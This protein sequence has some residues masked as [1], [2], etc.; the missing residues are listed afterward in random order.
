MAKYELP[1]LRPELVVC[2]A[3]GEGT[4]GR[5]GVHSQRERR[6]KCHRCHKTFSDT[7]GTPLYGLKHPTWLVVVVLTLLAF[8]C[9]LQAIV[10]AFGLDERTVSDW[11]QKAGR[12]AQRVQAE[13]VCNGQV[14]VGQVQG[15][16]FYVKT[17][18]G[19]VWIATG[20]SVF[21]RLFLWGALSIERN[22]ALVTQVVE[23]VKAAAQPQQPILWAVDGFT[24]WVSAILTLFRTSQHSGQRGR[25][26]LLVWPD[27]HIVQVVKRYAARRLV[28]VERRVV[29]G[30]PQAA[31]MLVCTTQVELG[32]FNT[33]YIERLNATFRTWLPQATRRS[34]TPAARR[35]QLE[36]A[37][38]WMAAVY[39]FCHLHASLQATPAM[40]AGLTDSL[41]SIDQ[42][43]RYRFRRE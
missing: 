14:D 25:P 13:V 33:A 21:S 19:A 24:A 35:S 8:G 17:Q 26:R 5:I 27:L 29:Y 10:A 4:N 43:L 38:F 1:P 2:P 11:Q 28:A 9:P 12:H 31:E 7:H 40:A 23:Q 32:C 41:W 39:N 18:C 30:A 34:R 42:L 15:D 3:C 20:M 6:Y 16:E 37:L 22:S 36:A